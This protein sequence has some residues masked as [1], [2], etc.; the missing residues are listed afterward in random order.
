MWLDVR[1]LYYYTKFTHILINIF[2]CHNNHYIDQKKK[3]ETKFIWYFILLVH[4][5]VQNLAKKKKTLEGKKV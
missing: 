2:W 3:K 1:R 5:P 4:E